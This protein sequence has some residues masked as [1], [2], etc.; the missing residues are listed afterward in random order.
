MSN[1]ELAVLI[2]EGRIDLFPELYEQTYKLLIKIAHRLF[3]LNEF[4]LKTAGIEFDDLTQESY[5][6]L[7]EAVKAYNGEYMFTSFLNYS[8]RNR[9][10]SLIGKKH[11]AVLRSD[12]LDKPITG[13]ESEELTLADIIPSPNNEINRI[14]KK[15]FTR[16]LHNDLEKCLSKLNPQAQET[17]KARFYHNMTYESLALKNNITVQEVQNQLNKSMRKLRQGRS[18]QTLKAYRDDINF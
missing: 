5:F 9:I 10:R 17:I 11:D 18:L 6:A 4:I 15:E 7:K 3:R 8:L 16:Q 2:Q 13:N 12:S 1:E 14:I